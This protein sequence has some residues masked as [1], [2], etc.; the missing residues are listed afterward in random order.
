MRSL[1]IIFLVIALGLGSY[2]AYNMYNK[3]HEDLHSQKADHSIM[4]NELFMAFANDELKANEKYL[5]KLIELEGTITKLEKAVEGKTQVYLQSD[6][7]MFGVICELDTS[8]DPA[9][10][11]VGQ[12]ITVKGICS[13]YLMDVAINRCVI[14]K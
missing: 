6:D 8:E 9:Q 2:L 12:A 4:A 14:I 7:P 1:V 11:Q 3:G 13:G 5:D 10:L